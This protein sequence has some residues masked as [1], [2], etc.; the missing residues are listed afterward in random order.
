MK[1]FISALG[2][3]EFVVF[4]D[5][6]SIPIDDI[7]KIDLDFKLGVASANCVCLFLKNQE[8]IVMPFEKADAIREFLIQNKIEYLNEQYVS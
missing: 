8:K 4:E 3:R 2:Q 6:F 7:E 1:I 5:L